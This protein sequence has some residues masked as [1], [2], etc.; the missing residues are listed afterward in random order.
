MQDPNWVAFDERSIALN[1]GSNSPMNIVLILTKLIFVFYL[2]VEQSPTRTQTWKNLAYDE[3][4]QMPLMRD[5]E[6]IT[7]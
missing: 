7:I 1:K 4:K 2:I 5:L 6:H 3:N